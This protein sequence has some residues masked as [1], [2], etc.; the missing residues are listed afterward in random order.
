MVKRTIVVAAAVA[1][2]R[3]GA[4]WLS[5][6]GGEGERPP[7]LDAGAGGEGGE[8][9]ATDDG[10]P[11]DAPADVAK[12]IAANLKQRYPATR[13]DQVVPSPLPGLYEVVMGLNV[14]FSDAE[15]R[16]FVNNSE[17]VNSRIDTLKAALQQL[18]GEP[19]EQSVVLKN[20]GGLFSAPST[21]PV[22]S[23]V[24]TSPKPMLMPLPPI[25][26][27]VSTNSGLPIMRT[28]TP[29]RSAGVLTSFLV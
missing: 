21:T 15:G 13:I 7:A 29:F 28:F 1:A 20:D 11:P 17:V 22:C 26:F 9:G 24:K 27:M 8:G 18:G 6:C 14:A 16:Y 2:S 5:G 10:G 4:V 12:S 23:A 3:A 19:A 25:A